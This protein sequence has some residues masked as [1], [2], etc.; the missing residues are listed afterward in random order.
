MLGNWASYNSNPGIHEEKYM[1]YTYNIYI[2][3][4]TY[5]L[6]SAFKEFA[7]TWVR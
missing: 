7:S 4:Y 5:T 2:Y 6:R 3:I 1:V